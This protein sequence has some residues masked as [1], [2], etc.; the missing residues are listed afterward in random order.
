MTYGPT[1]PLVKRL[2]QSALVLVLKAFP[3]FSDRYKMHTE[4]L[5]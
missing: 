1:T 4:E 3:R 2:S 5:H